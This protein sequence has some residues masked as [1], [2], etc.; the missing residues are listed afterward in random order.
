MRGTCLQL[1][2][3]VKRQLFRLSNSITRNRLS[4]GEKVEYL[5]SLK[6]TLDGHFEFYALNPV[7]LPY[8]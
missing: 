6:I 3:I 8:L 7:K 5:E 2:P 1:M 4:A